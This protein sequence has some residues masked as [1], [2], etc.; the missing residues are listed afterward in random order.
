MS[1]KKIPESLKNLEIRKPY[2]RF[3]FQGEEPK[4]LQIQEA[5]A[6]KEFYFIFQDRPLASVV[7]PKKQAERFLVEKNFSENDLVILLGL[8]NPHLA[9][10]IQKQLRAGQIFLLIDSIYDLAYVGFEIFQEILQ[11]AGRHLFCGESSL[12]LLWNYLESLPIEKL[13]G[14]KLIKNP[15]SLNLEKNFYL[16][17][18]E[19][20]NQIINSKMSD[21]LT[22]FEFERVWIRNTIINTLNFNL[23]QTP[24]YKLSEI[25][26]ILEGIPSVLVSAGPSLRKQCEWLKTV[27]DKVFIFS[28]DTSLKVLLKF[29]I[30]PDAVM[31]LDAQTNSYFHFMGEDVSQIPLFADMVTSPLLLRNLKFCSVVHSITAKYL[32]N[33]AGEPIR[34][35]TAGS[36]IAETYLGEIGDV[37]S[38]GSV[39]TSAFDVLRVLGCKEIYLLGQD[40]AYVGWEIHSTGTHHNEKWLGLINRKTSLEK[41]N[42][43]ICRKRKIK[44]VESN[45]SKPVLTDYVLGIYQRWFEES[46]QKIDFFVYNINIKGAKIQG[47][48]SITLEEASNLLSKYKEHSYP[49]R[50]LSVWKTQKQNQKET[51]IPN[52]LNEILSFEKVFTSIA[53]LNLSDEQ[54]FDILQ[55]EL[56]SRPY[57]QSMIRKTQIY[58]KRHANLEFTKKKELL[59]TALK[60]ELRFLKRGILAY[61]SN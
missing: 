8:G 59:V 61:T 37:Q 33:A 29:G 47:I 31:T 55:M 36:E 22:K 26:K 48:P 20:I 44:W 34:E 27:R 38:G 30:I 6:S 2:L 49:W 51:Y 12:E 39:A 58:L 14:V 10:E 42:I 50:N 15:S 54:A 28:C 18:E 9:L 3:Y 11:T 40:L 46:S 5:K 60:R 41:I 43:A 52:F 53:N 32:F 4:D 35:T 24:R 57:I 13:T 56:Q 23:P 1:L 45:E 19:K 21:L 25:G 17:V 16:Q 7:S